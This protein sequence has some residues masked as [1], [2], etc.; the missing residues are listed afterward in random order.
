MKLRYRMMTALGLA[1]AAGVA[2]AVAATV[3]DP[4]PAMNAPDAVAWDLFL[5][6]NAPAGPTNALFETWGSDTDLFQPNPKWPTGPTPS[7]LHPPALAMALQEELQKKGRLIPAVPPGKGALE[8]TRRNKPAFDFIVNN[9]LYSVSGLKAAFGKD[10]SFPVDSLEVKA[11]W[12]LVSEVPEWT[13]NRVQPADVPKYF[14][15]NKGADGQMYALIAMHVI[16]KAVPNWTW[17][18]FE[19]RFNPSRCDIIGC[20]DAFGA[21]QAVVAPNPQPGTGYPD[22]AKTPALLAMFGKAKIA[23]VFQNYCLKGSQVDFT[24]NTG[25]AVRLGNSITEAGFVDTASCM[26]CHA[27]AAWNAQG[28]PTS[29]GGFLPNGDGPL[30]AIDPHWFWQATGQ[31]PLYQGMPGL[32]RIATGGDFVWS[33]PF[34]AYDD[35]N[36]A[37]PKPSRCSGK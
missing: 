23:A 32:T 37:N 17:A 35:S 15:V 27:R 20:R 33:I 12:K 7:A 1:S 6:V 5:Q 2:M 13:G 10:L 9:K 8:E 36:P 24:D 3:A 29:G 26:T 30:G 19:N 28:K 34:C 14:H 22:C 25:L 18:T 31:P 21:T 16:S 4:N 11:S